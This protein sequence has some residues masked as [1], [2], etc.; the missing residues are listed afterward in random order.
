MVKLNYRLKGTTLVETIVSMVLIVLIIAMVVKT[1][2]QTEKVVG[3]EVKPYAAFLARVNI[4]N[5][6]R[7]EGSMEYTDEY[8]GL[9]I[10]KTLSCYKNISNLFL[11]EVD[12][13]NSD[14]RLIECKKRIVSLYS[15]DNQPESE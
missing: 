8:S 5:A 9:R 13:V 7:N 10:V 1:M 2:L 4:E 11:Y 14:N 6:P 15:I 3:T 12:I